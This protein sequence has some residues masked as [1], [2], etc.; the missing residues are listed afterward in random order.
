MNA[1]TGLDFYQFSL[2]AS[3]AND[4]GIPGTLYTDSRAKLAEALGLRDGAQ[5]GA[6][7]AHTTLFF[8]AR[9]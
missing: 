7:A 3:P 9:Q 8:H 4:G 1:A 2:P 6:T 5:V